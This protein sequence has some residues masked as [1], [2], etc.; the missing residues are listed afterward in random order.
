MFFH[1]GEQCGIEYSSGRGNLQQTSINALKGFITVSL[2][3]TV[4]VRLYALS[5]SLQ[6]T[7]ATGLTGCGS[8]SG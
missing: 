5:V 4:P 6:G 8:S 2:F 1:L 7:F 3:T